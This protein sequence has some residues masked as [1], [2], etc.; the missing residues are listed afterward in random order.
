[1]SDKSDSSISE[2]S[3]KLLDDEDRKVK[4]LKLQDKI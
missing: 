1:M 3:D 2:D 4:I